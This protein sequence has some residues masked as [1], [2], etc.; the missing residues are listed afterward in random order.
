MSAQTAKRGLD[1]SLHAAR[2]CV[3]RIGGSSV[4]WHGSMKATSELGTDGSAE[5]RHPLSLPGPGVLK[6]A[7]NGGPG[8]RPTPPIPVSGLRAMAG[9]TDAGP[10]AQRK[11]REVSACEG[12]G[13]GD[14]A[15][16]AD[17][18]LG[19]RGAAHAGRCARR[20]GAGRPAQVRRQCT[21]ASTSSSSGLRRARALRGT[22]RTRAL[23]ADSRGA[24]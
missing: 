1:G 12:C 22:R 6:G 3:I 16:V 19:A 13:R 15:A 23:R 24:V 5:S 2:T 11:A 17:A 20:W 4:C 9:L 8:P 21:R 7:P 10:P 14:V 18:R